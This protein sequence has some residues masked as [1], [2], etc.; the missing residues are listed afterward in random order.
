MSETNS[1]QQRNCA[2]CGKPVVD[3]GTGGVA[4]IGGGA[5]E[6]KCRNCGWSGGQYQ[7]FVHCPRCGDSTQMYD[8]HSAK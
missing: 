2:V 4:H 6:Q 1:N 3:N 5:V 8:D 7:K